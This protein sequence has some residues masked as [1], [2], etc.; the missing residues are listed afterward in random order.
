MASRLQSPLR[1]VA[2]QAGTILART[3]VWNRP[4][5][6]ATRVAF[7]TNAHHFFAAPHGKVAFT[8]G[9]YPHIERNKDFKMVNALYLL[10]K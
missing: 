5:T 10:S 2:R 4:V 8:A 6:W 3:P 7:S 9:K 1:L